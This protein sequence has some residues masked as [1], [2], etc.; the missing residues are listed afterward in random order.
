M[1][2][3]STH[4]SVYFFS[5]C[6]PGS[7]LTIRGKVGKFQMFPNGTL[8]IQNANIRD[9]GQYVC[10]AENIHGSDKLLITLTVVAHPA[11][12]LD[13]EIRDIKLHSG[14][15]AEMRCRAEGS[16]TPILLWILA[17]RTQVRSH[18]N[19]NGRVTLTPD[20]T[21]IIRRVTVYDR[22]HYKCIASNIDGMDT[23]SVRLQVVAAPPVIL[24]EKRQLVRADVG[25]SVWMNCTAQGDPQPTTRWVMMD[26]TAAKSIHTDSRMSSLLNG[27]LYVKNLVVSDSGMYECIATSSTGSERRVVTLSVENTESAPYITETSD[28]R[29]ELEY[30]ALLQLNCSASGNPRPRIMWRL[31]SKALV[32]QWH[33]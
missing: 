8:L 18:E 17:N 28:R 3:L 25:Q 21:L 27:T 5:V 16:P 4:C 12:I 7:T 29:T 1:L 2:F 30:G 13:P 23:A 24:E 33:K 11:R 22:G 31:P 15:Q 14:Q 9:R 20:G 10:L 19:G 32:D 26:G 6:V